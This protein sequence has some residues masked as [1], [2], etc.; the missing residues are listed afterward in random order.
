MHEGGDGMVRGELFEHVLGGG[1]D[2]ALA[3]LHGL[4]EAH[5]GEEDFA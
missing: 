4:G 1:D 3:V 2:F 5:D